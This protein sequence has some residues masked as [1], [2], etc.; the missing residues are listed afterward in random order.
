VNAK[1]ETR[2]F[3]TAGALIAAIRS[4]NPVVLLTCQPLIVAPAR[5]VTAATINIMAREGRGL[6]CHAMTAAQMLDLG[7]SLIPSTGRVPG[8]WRFAVSYEAGSGCSTGI[9]AAD[10][11]CTLNA[12]AAAGPGP[13]AIITPGHIIP[14]LGDPFGPPGHPPSAALQLM[15]LAGLCGGAAICTILDA[16]GAVASPQSA[17]QLA[18]RLGLRAELPG[19]VSPRAAAH[20]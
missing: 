16:D 1:P 11:A 7:L 3:D 12:G 10:R 2:Q 15:D 9:S 20:V 4:G 8:A 6:I 17:A 18:A 19:A 13:G 5:G 14:V